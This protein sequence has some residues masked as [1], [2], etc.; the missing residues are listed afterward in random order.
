MLP[1][2]LIPLALACPPGQLGSPAQAPLPDG[3]EAAIVSL[4]GGTGVVVSETGLVLTNHHIAAEV[5][6]EGVA[7]QP[8]GSEVAIL[9]VTRLQTFPALDAALY[10]LQG[11]TPAPHL[12]LRAEP[13]RAQE[14]IVL[15]GHAD[16]GPLRASCGVIDAPS[17]EIVE[18][19]ALTH[20]ARALQG[21]S[22]SPLID[23][24]GQVVGLHWGRLVYG[25]T[26]GSAFGARSTDLIAA[27]PA[28]AAA[29]GRCDQDAA[30]WIDADVRGEQTV[31]AA[32]ISLQGTPAC[33]PRVAAVIWTLYL[34]E[35]TIRV[36]GDTDAEGFPVEVAVWDRFSVTAQVW[37]EGF[38]RPIAVDGMVRW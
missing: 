17:A 12:P 27:S 10:Q 13:A 6:A 3:A 20:T 35:D 18:T 8:R 23:A 38:A 26:Q 25:D 29:A 30:W 32:T 28:L 2:L 15:L 37:L 19:T 34:T 4:G 22:G 16:G 36:Q 24:D 5:G 33:A 31:R 1:S 9:P 21:S 14:P 7:L 11:A